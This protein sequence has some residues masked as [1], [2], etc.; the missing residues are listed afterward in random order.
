MSPSTPRMLLAVASAGVIASLLTGCGIL[1][2]L[3]GGGDATRDE[4][5]QVI[6]GNEAS[7]VFLMR[8]GDCLNDSASG[9]EVS[10]V[11][12]VPCAEPHDSEIYSELR[13]SGSEFPGVATIEEQ[14]DEHCYTAFAEFVGVD[15]DSSELY[16]SYYMP[17]EGSWN[18]FDDRLVSCVIVDPAGQTTGSLKGAAR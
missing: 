17:T 10:Q 16:F 13:L 15:Y 14:A 5:G 4:T 12:I 9:D 18:D 1:Q 2:S 3:T 7:D 6:E 11:P 8:V